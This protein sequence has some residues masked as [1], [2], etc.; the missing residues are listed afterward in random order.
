MSKTAN[1]IRFLPTVLNARV[2]DM[3]DTK[4]AFSVSGSANHSSKVF[5]IVDVLKEHKNNMGGV[6]IVNNSQEVDAVTKNLRVLGGFEIDLFDSR[7]TQIVPSK[8]DRLRKM[9]TMELLALIRSERKRFLILPYFELLKRSPDLDWVEKVKLPLEK[10]KHIDLMSFYE[11]LIALGYEISEDSY[12][13]KGT[14]FRS[15]DVLTI[16]PVNS[17]FPLRISLGFDTVESL[18]FFDQDTVERDVLSEEKKV[19]LWPIFFEEADYML[20]DIFRKD[21]LVIEDDLE[22]FDEF[23]EDW[24]ASFNEVYNKNQVLSFVT[25]NED[26]SS[27]VHLHYLSVL[28]YRGTYDLVNDLFLNQESAGNHKWKIIL[29]QSWSRSARII[30]DY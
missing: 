28:K 18:E 6:W 19:S 24:N 25:F 5:T 15:G 23:Y 27:H 9:K 21:N 26:E 17:Q 2:L 7:L 8:V 30:T 13:Q 22:I 14:Y 11:S 29:C 1:L 4:R 3:L 16:F 10:G 12:L 20:V